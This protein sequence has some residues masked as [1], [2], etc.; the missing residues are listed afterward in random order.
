MEV[1]RMQRFSVTVSV[2]DFDDV[3]Y[4]RCRRRSARAKC[5]VGSVTIAEYTLEAVS[6][7]AMATMNADCGQWIDTSKWSGV[8]VHRVETAKPGLHYSAMGWGHGGHDHVHVTYTF[9]A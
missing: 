7:A 9:V 5:R 1:Q 2:L 4:T 6:G 3:L 8:G